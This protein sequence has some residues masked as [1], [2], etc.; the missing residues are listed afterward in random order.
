M[1][2]SSLSHALCVRLQFA[3]K[4]SA[5]RLTVVKPEVG[6]AAAEA[7]RGRGRGRGGDAGRGRGRT[8]FKLQQGEVRKA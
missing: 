1:V 8:D 4:I 3:P 5:P 6:G 7:P 2:V